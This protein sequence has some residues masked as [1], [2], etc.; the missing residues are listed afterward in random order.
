MTARNWPRRPCPE[1]TGSRYDYELATAAQLRTMR[2]G[3]REWLPAVTSDPDL[4][5]E[6]LL[7][8]DELASNGLRHGLPPV[9]VSVAPSAGDLLLAVSDAVPECAPEPA[10]GRDPAQGGMGLNLV[11]DLSIACGWDVH[12]GRKHVWACLSRG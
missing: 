12:D 1:T 7:T 5:D 2:A 9:R 10:T 4:L 11:A 3:L 8:L 6:L